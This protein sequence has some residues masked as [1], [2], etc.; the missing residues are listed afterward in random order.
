MF[1]CN[2]WCFPWTIS[3]RR[4][5]PRLPARGARARR[6]TRL[7]AEHGVTAPLRR[8]DRDVDAARRHAAR[9][10]GRCRTASSSS[11]RRR[12]R[13]RRCSARME[14]AGF[15]VTHLYGLTETYGPAV[16]NEWHAEWD[17]LPPAERAAQKARQGVRYPPLEGLD[18]L[19]PETMEPVPA[20]GETIGEVMFRGNVVMK[21]YLKNPAATEAALRGRLVP[22]RRPR[23][24]APRRLCPAQ[25]PLEG[26]HH[27]RRRE[28]LVD[29][30]R[31]GA[32]Q[33]SRRCRL[34]PSWPSRTSGGARRRVRSSS[35]GRARPRPRRS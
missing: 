32:L 34:R 6:C 8:A 4:R 13:P 5:H 35:C 18:V 19:D 33:A 15:D 1:H 12:R 31:G 3:R 27:L 9:S 23:R 10:A 17:A 25:G 2:G 29:R 30:G 26:H 16:V 14:E 7:I 24:Q 22:L 21:G 28:H 20:D 11:P